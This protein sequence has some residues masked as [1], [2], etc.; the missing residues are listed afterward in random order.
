MNV[1]SYSGHNTLRDAVLG[2]NFK[3]KATQA[4]IDSMKSLVANRYGG[5]RHWALHRIGIWPGIYSARDEVLQLAN[6]LPQFNGRSISHLRSEDRFFW[7]ALHE[8]ITIGQETKVPC[9]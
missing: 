3:R 6:V 7:D 1:A 9:K 8:I 4:E 2:G 5:G